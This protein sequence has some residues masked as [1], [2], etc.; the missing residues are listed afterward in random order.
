MIHQISGH[1]EISRLSG[2][3]GHL[4]DS[5]SI[6]WNLAIIL[7]SIQI[8]IIRLMSLLLLDVQL[9]L[10]FRLSLIDEKELVRWFHDYS[11]QYWP[12]SYKSF[13]WIILLA[14]VTAPWTFV[15]SSPSLV[16]FWFFTASIHWTVRSC[17]TA[18]NWWLF[19]I[20]FCALLFSSH[21]SL[22]FVESI[23]FGLCG[24]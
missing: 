18:A 16:K 15:N 22:L 6:S 1:I 19:G 17:T 7:R 11:S 4:A 23:P 24:S 3:L 2:G 8:A 12:N 14:S 13:M 10:Q 9:V 5:D 21:Q 20:N